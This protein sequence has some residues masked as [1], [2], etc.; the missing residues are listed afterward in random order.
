MIIKDALYT[1]RRKVL[2]QDALTQSLFAS[3]SDP[4]K[5]ETRPRFV[6]SG[7]NEMR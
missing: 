1:Y 7:E 5:E 6:G 4:K 2:R 3:T